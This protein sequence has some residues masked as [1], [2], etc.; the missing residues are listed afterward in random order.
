MQNYPNATETHLPFPPDNGNIIMSNQ[1]LGSASTCGS[2]ASRPS[3][4]CLPLCTRSGTRPSVGC[5]G[6]KIKLDRHKSWIYDN[7]GEKLSHTSLVDFRAHTQ[8]QKYFISP[9]LTNVQTYQFKTYPCKTLN[10]L[11]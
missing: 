9:N 8:T 3:C 10:I 6:S 4:L 2:W 5:P 7:Y 1:G 11:H